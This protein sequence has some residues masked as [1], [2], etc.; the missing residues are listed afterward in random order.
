MR[1]YFPRVRYPDRSV[2][3]VFPACSFS[4]PDNST[5]IGK[6]TL[7]MRVKAASTV[8]F[9]LRFGQVPGQSFVPEVIGHVFVGRPGFPIPT[10]RICQSGHNAGLFSEGQLPQPASPAG[11]PACSF[12]IPDNSARIGRST[13]FMRVKAASTVQFG[14]TFGQV[15]GQSFVPEVIGR[16]FRVP[17]GFTIPSTRICQS[18]HNAGLFSESPLPRPASSAGFPA[19]SFGIPDNSTRIGRST[20]FMRVKAASTVQFGLRIACQFAF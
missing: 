13:V 4:I 16:F 15:P 5:R 12:E 11:F 8:Q 6:S 19:C 17:P 14:L 1:G 18:G 10:T 2:Q 3:R 7:S 9:G 20:V